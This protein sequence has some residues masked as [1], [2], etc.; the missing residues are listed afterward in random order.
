LY[1][2]EWRRRD[3]E[4]YDRALAFGTWLPAIRKAVERDLDSRGPC[5]SRVVAA[6]VRLIDLGFFR[7]GGTEYAE[8]NGSYGLTTIRREHVRCRAGQLYFGYPGK[9]GK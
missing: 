7:P 2:A 5:N 3:R 9:S 6:A 4:K 1:H 8:E